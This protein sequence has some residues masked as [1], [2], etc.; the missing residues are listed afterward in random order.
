MFQIVLLA[1]LA[2][3]NGVR[4]RQKGLNVVLWGALTV[5]SFFFAFA[6]GVGVVT[7]NFLGESFNL[8]RLST[9]QGTEREEAVKQFQDLFFA[10]PLHFL[11]VI[12]FGIGG[13]L[14]I[15]FILEKKPNKKEPE[16]HWMDK[17]GE[18]R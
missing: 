16:V 10:N 12:L 18:N 9:L 1:Y 8:Q 6:L 3:R 15:R 7:A 5:L 14:L 4:A 13:Y 11:T 2:F 17:L